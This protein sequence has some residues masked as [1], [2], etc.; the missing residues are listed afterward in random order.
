[1]SITDLLAGITTDKEIILYCASSVRAG[2]VYI[3]LTSILEFPN[4][5]VYDGAFYEWDAD[6]SNPIE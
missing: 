1:M 3:A 4:V 6:S 5:R 2:I